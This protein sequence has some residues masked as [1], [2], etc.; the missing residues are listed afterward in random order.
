M[1]I[2]YSTFT[3]YLHFYGLSPGTLH[4]HLKLHNVG[5]TDYGQ[6]HIP[7]PPLEVLDHSQSSVRIAGEKCEQKSVYQTR[8]NVSELPQ[9][10]RKLVRRVFPILFAMLYSF[11]PQLTRCSAT[12]GLTVAQG[13][14][15]GT[16]LDDIG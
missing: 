4:A 1:D 15:G 13:L 11:P 10:T 16:P 3:H 2:F 9:F 8:G 6:S 14:L 7:Y 12:Q 5:T